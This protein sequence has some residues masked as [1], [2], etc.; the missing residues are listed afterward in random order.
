VEER[1]RGAGLGYALNV[2]LPS[3]SGNG[4]YLE[5]LRQVVAPALR[6]FE[7]AMM[8]VASGFDGSFMDPLGRM[9]VTTT[10]YRAMTRLLMELADE[11]CGGRLVMVHE[12]GYS[13]LYVPFC[14]IA[15]IET[16][17]GVE[18]GIAMP[19]DDEWDRMPDQAVT[20]RQAT[21]IARAAA[22]AASL[23][24]TAARA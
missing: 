12:G 5:A 13:L 18:T 1:G 19:W 24:N 2:P 15:V 21:V 6:A 14:G 11:I 16:L 20:D 17:A 10:G 9:M 8:I 23:R 4:A 22:N 7:P 3:G